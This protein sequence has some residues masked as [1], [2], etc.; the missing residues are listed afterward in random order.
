MFADVV[1]VRH[2]KSVPPPEAGPDDFRRPLTPEGLRQAQDLARALAELYPV[3]VWSSPYPRAVQTVEPTARVLGLV[4]RTWWNLREWNDGM[5][6][7][8]DWTAQEVRS[9]ADPSFARPGGESLDQLTRRASGAVR[10]LAKRYAG[11]RVLIGSHGTFVARALH[12]LGVAVGHSFVRDMP[13]PAVYRVRFT[14]EGEQPLIAG[15]GLSAQTRGEAF[16]GS[17]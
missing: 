14:G 3:A 7:G 16:P 15:P 1:L 5:P 6:A 11:Q 13:M 9:W 17:T 2:A 12:G 10:S 4:V 8:S